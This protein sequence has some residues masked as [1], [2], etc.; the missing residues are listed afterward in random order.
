VWDIL[1]FVEPALGNAR[2]LLCSA[3]RRLHEC[4]GCFTPPWAV[5]KCAMDVVTAESLRSTAMRTF[6]FTVRWLMP[7]GVVWL[8]AVAVCIC[9]ST[10]RH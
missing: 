9:L 2:V 6:V 5:E 10:N 8:S 1:R 4:D 3:E 7:R